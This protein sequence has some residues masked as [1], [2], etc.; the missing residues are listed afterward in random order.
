MTVFKYL[1]LIS[2]D[3]SILFLRFLV[4]FTFDWEDTLN[5]QKKAW[6]NF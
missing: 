3:L 2:I 6:L 5:I 1:I 4:S